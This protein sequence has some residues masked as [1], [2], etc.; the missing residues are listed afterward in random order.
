[1]P[2]WWHCVPSYRNIRFSHSI[3][4][5]SL[6]YHFGTHGVERVFAKSDHHSWQKKNISPLSKPHHTNMHSVLENGDL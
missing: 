1:M 6:M 4:N 3:H 5:S 2:L